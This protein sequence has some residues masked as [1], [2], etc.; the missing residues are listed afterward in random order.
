MPNLYLVSTIMTILQK[1]IAQKK[2]ITLIAFP[3]Y[4]TN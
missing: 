4:D 3:I 1:K 2:A